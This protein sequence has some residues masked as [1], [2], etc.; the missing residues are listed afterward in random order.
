MKEWTL[1]DALSTIQMVIWI[2]TIL[3]VFTCI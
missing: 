1:N 2:A 3:A